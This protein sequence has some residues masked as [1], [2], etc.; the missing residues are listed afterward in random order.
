MIQKCSIWIVLREF[1]E[2]PSGKMHIRTISKKINLAPTSVKLHIKT[3]IKENLIIEKDDE[4]FKYYAANFDSEKFRFYKKI[5]FLINIQ[6]SGLKEHLDNELSPDAII[7]FGSAAKGEDLQSG[8]IDIFVQAKE[9]S[10]NL[11]KYEK[12]LN[13]RIQLFFAEDI[14]KLPKELRNNILN[15]T[16]LEGYI[17]VF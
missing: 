17:K 3:L 11:E 12:K 13:K 2:N 15:G 4:I 6:E 9:K 7:L 5:N 8:D 10:I 14:G 1:L 16:K